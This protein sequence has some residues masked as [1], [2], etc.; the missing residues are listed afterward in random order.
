M[1]KVVYSLA[2]G[3]LL[4]GA[5]CAPTSTTTSVNGG[6]KT[7]QNSLYNFEFSYPGNGKESTP[8]YGNLDEK[9][10]QIDLPDEKVAEA[11]FI[12]TA[13]PLG[14][15]N[16][17]L[18]LSLPNDSVKF[19][20]KKT[21]NGVEYYTADATDESGGE[22]FDS[23]LYRTFQDNECFEFEQSVHTSSDDQTSDTDK[24]AATASLESIMNSVKFTQPKS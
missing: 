16:D 21:I 17:C 12:V 22:R 8:T 6:P 14:E 24:S 7:Y 5:G 13:L 10:V 19:E 23:K 11:Q 18:T 2:A 4:L 20:N 9:L 1:K 3:V 15:L